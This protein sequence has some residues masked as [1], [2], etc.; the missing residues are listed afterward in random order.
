TRKGGKGNIFVNDD[1]LQVVTEEERARRI[2][3]YERTGISYVARPPD[4]VRK[5]RG[6]F[7]KAS[8]MNY[9]LNVSAKVEQLMETATANNTPMSVADALFQVWSSE[10]YNREFLA[11]GDIRIRD[12]ILLVDADTR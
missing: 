11:G 10:E 12:L 4:S 9:C 8:N 6:L 1:G 7:K 3:F 5:R 2:A